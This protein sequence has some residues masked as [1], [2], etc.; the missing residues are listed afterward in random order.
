MSLHESSHPA[1]F[2]DLSGMRAVVTGSSTGIG[3]AMA[4]ELARGGADVAVHCHDSVAEARAVADDIQALGRDTLVVAADVSRERG[5]QT[6]LDDVLDRWSAVD[7]WINNAGADV[8]TG[9][10]AQLPYADKLQRLWN[11]D[12]MGTMLLCKDI[13]RRMLE[14]GQGVI[15][16]IG[17]DQAAD[18]MAGDSGELFSA[19]KGAIMSFSRSLALSL[20]PNVRVHCIAPGWIKTDWGASASETWQQRVIRETPLKRWGTPEDI[21]SLAR[22]LCSREAE[23]LTGQVWNANGGAVRS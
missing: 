21:A 7:I 16:N 23:Y 1:P 2:A 20:A 5:R 17:W 19:T 15:I 12:V 4:L 22:F 9:S 13:G 6:L 14:W 8:L 3:R 11:V 18:G 10:D